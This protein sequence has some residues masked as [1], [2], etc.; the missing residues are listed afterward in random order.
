PTTRTGAARG[1]HSLTRLF[2]NV[3]TPTR[4]R[5]SSSRL[6]S[7][8]SVSRLLARTPGC[9]KSAA[10]TAATCCRLRTPLASTRT[11]T[12]RPARAARMA[13][14]GSRLGRPSRPSPCASTSTW[15][16]APGRAVGP[17]GPPRASTKP[18][19]SSPV[20]PFMRMA[21]RNAPTCASSRV[22][23][24]AR[25]AAA[26]SARARLR[27]R[28]LPAP[29]ALMK[30][31][32][33]ISPVP[34]ALTSVKGSRSASGLRPQASGLKPL[35][36]YSG[37]RL[38]SLGSGLLAPGRHASVVVGAPARGF[39]VGHREQ[40]EAHA[41]RALDVAEAH[42]GVAVERRVAVGHVKPQPDQASDR[43]LAPGL[44]EQAVQRNIAD[45]ARKA[46]LG[47]AELDQKPGL[48][49]LGTTL[50]AALHAL[51]IGPRTSSLSQVFSAIFLRA[52]AGGVSVE[53]MGGTRR[54]R[55]QARLAHKLARRCPKLSP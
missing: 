45:L 52:R 49:A 21:R 2:T 5:I 48:D 36:G 22:A 3:R 11:S 10:S 16:C 47:R 6:R 29:T 42:P 30:A 35:G 38:R 33:P 4:A 15:G 19:S 12:S 24:S 26:A 44:D 25:M 18:A 14:A 20:S 1:L 43:A 28:F 55:R 31:C 46:G 17:P 51:V 41:A 34:P 40:L 27:A 8:C 9:G 50:F 32:T 39:G 23:S 13:A 7:G 37:V 53:T 54:S